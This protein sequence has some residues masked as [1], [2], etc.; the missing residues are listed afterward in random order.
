MKHYIF[1]L[2]MICSSFSSA[3]ELVE[4]SVYL[5]HSNGGRPFMIA[6]N[7]SRVDVYRKDYSID[8]KPGS[9]QQKYYPLHVKTYA[10]V[11]KVFIGD[12]DNNDSGYRGN[13]VL[14]Q[15]EDH[16][17]AFVGDGVFYEFRTGDIIESFYSLLGNSDV[18]YPIA[19]GKENIYMVIADEWTYKPRDLFVGF[20]QTYS[21]ERD[22][23]DKFYEI[24]VPA[25]KF[26][27]MKIIY[28]E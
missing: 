8:Y 27:D 21:W 5:T 18:P 20:P 4:D 16:L 28:R 19:V 24:D 23:Y 10:N 7:D 2:L 3:E 15:L 13:T 12:K 26:M 17:Y 22:A 11:Q 1:T 25:Q 9:D 14:I 6:I